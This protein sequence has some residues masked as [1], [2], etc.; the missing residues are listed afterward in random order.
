MALDPYGDVQGLTITLVGGGNSTLCL[1]PLIASAGYTVNILTRQP[2]KWAKEIEVV[3]EDMGFMRATS[4]KCIP[5]L[6]T[7]DP[8]ACIPQSDIIWFAGVPVHHNPSLLQNIKPH[9]T[10][11]KHYF[12][13]TICCYGGFEWVAQRELGVGNY[14]CFGT[15]LIPWCCGTKKYGETGVIFGAKRM[16]RIVTSKGHDRLRLKK[17]LAP[18][19]RQP[20]EDTHFLAS[21]LWPN[22]AMIHPPIL[23]GLFKDWDG[24][25]PF[26]EEKV[27]KAIYAEMTDE[28][29]E[30]VVKMDEELQELNKALRKLF[31]S[32]PHLQKD[33]RM[34]ECIL[35]N[36]K[37]QV[38]DPS[39][40]TTCFRTN[41][42]FA[43]HNIPYTKVSEGKVVPTIAH[44]FFETDLPYGLVT[45]RD[46]GD[47]VGVKMPF[48]TDMIRWNQKLIGKEFMLEDG[49]LGGKDIGEAIVPS[50][51]GL[52]AEDLLS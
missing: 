50:R 13:G 38:T 27:P 22:N 6:V 43:K 26:D 16:L 34:R 31:P 25:T 49:S 3:N 39:T 24:K 32:D 17:L 48:I 37:D 2:D 47:M 52:K 1:A 8:A 7:K 15:Q 41:A 30:C 21:T 19:L 45:F 12:I 36:Y 28:S 18:I 33:F 9:M 35:Q 5:N 14:S 29:G 11:G 4:I 44:K 42:A 51:M 40:T 23:Y 46:I 20:L 10:K